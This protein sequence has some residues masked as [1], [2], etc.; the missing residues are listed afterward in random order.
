MMIDIWHLDNP[1]TERV[2]ADGLVKGV[3]FDWLQDLT[4]RVMSVEDK[5]KYESR[6]E[7][8][9]NSNPQSNSVKDIKRVPEV[10]DCNWEH[11]KNRYDSEKG[12][13]TVETLMAGQDLDR[14]ME[15]E[16]LRRLDSD[17]KK[18]FL[19]A[20]GKNPARRTQASKNA[21]GDRIDR[22]RINS[23][24]VLSL[25]AEV[26]GQSTW[27]SDQPHV[28]F[29][30]FKIPIFFHERMEKELEKLEA[31]LG[32]T[33]ND[34]AALEQ[35]AATKGELGGTVP[36][37]AN[38][39]AHQAYSEIKCYV[40][41]VRN[42]LLPVHHK[43]DG[44]TYETRSKIQ[45]AE[46]WSLFSFGELVVERQ[47]DASEPQRAERAR[48]RQMGTKKSSERRVWKVFLIK[49]SV[50]DWGVDNLDAPG[51]TL[52]RSR[53]MP[54]DQ[55]FTVW[56]YR[57]DYDGEKYAAVERRFWISPFEKEKD[58]TKLPIYPIRFQR[59][60]DNM[61]KRLRSRGEKFQKLIKHEHRAI[62]YDGWTLLE[63]PSGDMLAGPSDTTRLTTVHVDSNVI[64]DFAEG[65]QSHPLWKPDFSA[66]SNEV[67]APSNKQD[68]FAIIQWSGTD[69]AREISR[70]IEVVI[71][72]DDVNELQWQKMAETDNFIV[73]RDQRAERLQDGTTLD[74]E[75]QVLTADD[76]AL[77]PARM[78]VYS[79]RDRFFVN[80]DVL[81]LKIPPP[82]PNPFDDLKIKAS[83]K[84]LIQSVVRDH[85]K[86]K[87]VHRQLQN[88]GDETLEQDFIPGKGK[89][90]I[91]LLHGPPGVG[92]TATAEA[93][94]YEHK[95]PLFPITCG[96][97]GIESSTVE[98]RLSQIF[99]LA[100]AWDCVL[101]LDEADIFLS[102][103]EKMDDSLQ[104]NALVS[105]TLTPKK[106]LIVSIALTQW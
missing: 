62:E 93:V 52:R 50:G 67:W 36:P 90:L 97:L 21:I 14:E 66:Y 35:T 54:L 105:G 64:I 101:L 60:S 48:Q 7:S 81:S 49:N 84:K 20:E 18:D 104:R 91:I 70:I 57:L 77:L 38:E 26:T 79:L 92:K 16:Q 63:D 88:K 1:W 19:A 8:S 25:L 27:T 17:A 98:D 23:P 3:A 43:F 56:A 69:R 13:P 72:D 71:E 68:M 39:T 99:R 41:F 15:E 78:M 32:E 86:K 46:L 75:K 100:N 2:A 37:E 30:P 95:K 12:I 10:R 59:D 58:I 34:Q 83:D 106:C 42:R 5:I 51:S 82:I 47:E 61:M 44:E 89:G 9:Q 87:Q 74:N 6:D 80:A 102:R 73:D 96:D 33:S 55:D 76:A 24:A 65:Y 45:F 85:F 103:R 22:V 31:A 28:F 29:S 11:F 40:E 4:R 53:E 94:A